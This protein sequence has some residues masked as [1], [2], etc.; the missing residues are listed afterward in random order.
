[1]TEDAKTGHVSTLNLPTVFNFPK[2]L[3]KV[4]ECIWIGFASMLELQNLLPFIYVTR[5][6]VDVNYTPSHTGNHYLST[7]MYSV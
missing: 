2:T 3:I 4:T 6:G 7:E 1:M 5:P